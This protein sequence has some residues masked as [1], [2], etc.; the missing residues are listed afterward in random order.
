MD[1]IK[2]LLGW[3][4][5]KL[6][7]KKVDKVYNNFTI[8]ENGDI[9]ERL[10]RFYLAYKMKKQE[11]N[12]QNGFEAVHKNFWSKSDTYFY[13]TKNRTE[14]IHIPSYKDIVQEVIPLL[15][16]KN[17][18]T[19]F[20]FGSGDGAWLNYLSQQWEVVKEFIGIDISQGQVDKNNR[21]Y[22]HL[23]FIKS[24][25]I[26]WAETNATPQALYH[27]CAGV[28]EYLSESSVK[29]LI[30]ILK[31]QAK[32]SLI[33]F[34]EPLYGDYDINKDTASKII[35][36]EHSYTHNYVHLLEMAG[37]EVINH[38]ERESMGQRMLIVLAYN[39]A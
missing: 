19:V 24:D 26:E 18:Q 32:G 30:N 33:F 21:K 25:L 12:S 13:D 37:I 9:A 5:A 6:F 4:L 35:G 14:E 34:I 29:R 28:L 36:Y 17:I 22:K 16:D 1:R 20:E 10:I 31:N 11:R 39:G 38:E 27:T 7:P 15:A 3:V 23:T 2:Y 8:P